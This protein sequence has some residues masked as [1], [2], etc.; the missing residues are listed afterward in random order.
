MLNL[1][2][3]CFQFFAKAIFF[4]DIFLFFFQTTLIFFRN[5]SPNEWRSDTA[6]LCNLSSTSFVY[7]IASPIPWHFYDLLCLPPQGLF[8]PYPFRSQVVQF[9][10]TLSDSSFAWTFIF[11]G[12]QFPIVRLSSP[13][14]FVW[15]IFCRR[16]SVF[17]TGPEWVSLS[18]RNQ[19]LLCSPLVLPKFAL[20]LSFQSLRDSIPLRWVTARQMIL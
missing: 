6:S 9:L 15:Y 2:T 7:S 8:P 4:N 1:L 14:S 12:F 13:F 10:F 16:A 5:D 17:W 11:F 19:R 18:S 3:T 20:S